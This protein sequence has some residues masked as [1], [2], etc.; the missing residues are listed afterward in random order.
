VHLTGFDIT[1]ET[2]KKYVESTRFAKRNNKIIAVNPVVNDRVFL[3]NY[4]TAPITESAC[5]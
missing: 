2:L 3:I 5:G 1:V 4:S